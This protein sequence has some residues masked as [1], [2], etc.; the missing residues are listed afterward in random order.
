MKASL[1]PYRTLSP[2]KLTA[3]LPLLVVLALPGLV[4]HDAKAIQVFTEDIEIQEATPDIIFTDTGVAGEDWLIRG[5]DEFFSL[6]DVGASDVLVADSFK[7]S[8]FLGYFASETG[9]QSIALGRQASSGGAASRW[10]IRP[11]LQG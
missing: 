8:I 5:R 7:K 9:D 6:V 10:A 4:I 2:L 3:S 1:A 11:L